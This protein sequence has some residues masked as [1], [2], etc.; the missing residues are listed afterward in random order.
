MWTSTPNQPYP[1]LGNTFFTAG[2]TIV[3]GVRS[4]LLCRCHLSCHNSG[5]CHLLF[6]V[7]KMYTNH[8]CSSGTSIWN[9][10]LWSASSAFL[11]SP[12]TNFW[13]MRFFTRGELSRKKS[14]RIQYIYPKVLA[15]VARRHNAGLGFGGLDIRDVSS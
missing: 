11:F 4:H 10:N 13:V 6:P 3:R 9:A 8:G 1:A 5:Y 12:C 14:W 15:Q 7:V 2:M